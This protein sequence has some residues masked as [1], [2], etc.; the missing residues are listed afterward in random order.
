MLEIATLGLL[1]E[2]PLHGYR[3]KQELETLMGGCISVNYGA[4]YPLLRRW[5]DR[6]AI[7]VLSEAEGKGAS[8]RR[9]YSLTESGRALWKQMMLDHPQESWVNSRARFMIKFC[10]LSYLLPEERLKLLNHRLMCSLRLE[11]EKAAILPPDL[12][13]RT[14]K[15]FFKEIIT[16]EIEWLQTQ[17]SLIQ[18]EIDSL[19]LLP[20][21]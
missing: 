19:S 18:V 6:G 13:R 4:I 1:M 14:A 8:G 21:H 20:S 3:L 2:Q 10:F 9:I 16:Q 5:E 15:Q 17:I 11:N 12:Y 7:A